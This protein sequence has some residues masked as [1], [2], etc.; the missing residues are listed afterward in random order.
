MRRYVGDGEVDVT[1][2]SENLCQTLLKNEK[3]RKV[4]DDPLFHNDVFAAFCEMLEGRNEAKI[5]RDLSLRLVPSAEAEAL[6]G[7]NHLRCVVESVNEGWNSSIPAA[8][9]RPQ[10][11][12]AV[13]FRKQAFTSSQLKKLQPCLGELT[14]Q[15]YFRATYYMYFPFLTCEVKCG[16]EAPLDIADRQNAH[17]MTL[18]VR[19]VALLYQVAGCE[20]QV[21][22]KVLA[23]SISHDHRNVR[24]YGHYPVFHGK[25][26]EYYRHMI[27][28]FDITARGG[29]EKWTALNFTKNLYH[30][31]V[32]RHLEELRSIIDKIPLDYLTRRE[33]L[34]QQQQEAR[35]SLNEESSQDVHGG[36]DQLSQ[37][38]ARPDAAASSLGQANNR[39]QSS[40]LALQAATPD[41]SL[42]LGTKQPLKR[43]KRKRAADE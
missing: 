2:G 17:S 15:S 12:Y 32:P 16:A 25:S 5:I 28:S 11:D 29:K 36:G 18:A 43:S 22:R 41:T 37:Q 33:S 38:S 4:P 19:A 31:W 39:Q 23:F 21:H 42:S 14:D 27:D 7:A 40:S 8:G 1:E 9:P 26:I 24:I 35:L 34:Q 13:G 10:P 20:K 30:D 3:E 6:C